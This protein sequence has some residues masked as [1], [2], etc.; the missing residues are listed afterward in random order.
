[1]ALSF[2]DYGSTDSDSILHD[3]LAWAFGYAF[4]KNGEFQQ[5]E[6]VKTV[7][8]WYKEESK[9]ERQEDGNNKNAILSLIA[10]KLTTE[11]VKLVEPQYK[12]YIIDCVELN[13]HFKTGVTQLNLIHFSETICEICQAS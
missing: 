9:E 12:A 6:G 4:D 8:E 7:A 3:K 11:L 1:M 2:G 13:T 10:N 5:S